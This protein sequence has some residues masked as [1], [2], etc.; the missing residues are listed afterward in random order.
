MKSRPIHLA[1]LGSRPFTGFGSEDAEPLSEALSAAYELIANDS[2]PG[3]SFIIE[4]DGVG[5]MNSSH[6]AQLL[7]IRK[8]LADRGCKLVLCGMNDSLWSVVHL[9]GL[10][11]V[12]KIAST[13]RDAQ[14]MMALEERG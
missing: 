12:F 7:R 8:R 11:R 13:L 10:D 1:K 5:Y 9:T 2:K 3:E 14:G 6:L 4:F